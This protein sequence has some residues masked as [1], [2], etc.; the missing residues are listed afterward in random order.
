MGVTGDPGMLNGVVWG[1]AQLKL[2]TE[3][4][5]CICGDVTDGGDIAGGVVE[6]AIVPSCNIV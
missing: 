5:L 1:L 3:C 4:D 6:A 2:G